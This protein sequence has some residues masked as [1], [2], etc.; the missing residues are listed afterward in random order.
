MNSDEIDPDML[1]SKYLVEGQSDRQIAAA[2]NVPEHRVYLARK[3]A[4]I[5][6]RPRGHNL[7]G[8]LR[9]QHDYGHWRGKSRAPETRQ[10]ISAAA[11]T[12]T[13][14][15]SGQFHPMF[16]K[17]GAANPNY[18]HGNSPERQRIYSTYQ[19]RCLIE[20]V[21]LRDGGRCR[22]CGLEIPFD[23]KQQHHHHFWSWD[24]YPEFRLHPDNVML[25]CRTCHEWIHSSLNVERYWVAPTREQ[26]TGASHE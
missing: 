19:W 13:N 22:R 7:S 9:P 17:Q 4:G 21:Y 11:Q 16:G 18:K 25:I 14:R 6:S 23:H 26:I 8:A 12:Q 20:F 3:A 10:K 24:E 5:P 15:P 2:L 1:R